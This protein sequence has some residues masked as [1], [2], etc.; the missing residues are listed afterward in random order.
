[1]IEPLMR[2]RLQTAVT[3]LEMMVSIAPSPF[4]DYRLA[5]AALDLV[6]HV[7]TDGAH[8]VSERTKTLV[9]EIAA[10]SVVPARLVSLADMEHSV[11]LTED[12]AKTLGA[13][14]ARR[15]DEL[16]RQTISRRLGREDWTVAE[17]GG[18]I[19]IDVYKARGARVLMLDGEAL[20]EMREASI[21]REGNR[22]VATINFRGAGE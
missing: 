19:S 1:M 9:K 2:A 5:W 17:L 18:R 4:D 6:K 20:L 10:Y 3:L 12:A 14:I 21:T 22:L 7:A 16:F 15:E 13:W 11:D 8:A